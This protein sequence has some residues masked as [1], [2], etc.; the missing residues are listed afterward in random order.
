MAGKRYGKEEYRH[1]NLVGWGLNTGPEILLAMP[2]TDFTCMFTW[3]GWQGAGW[4]RFWVFPLPL[5]SIPFP[6]KSLGWRKEFNSSHLILLISQEDRG[7]IPGF[8]ELPS[9]LCFWQLMPEMHINEEKVLV[10]IIKYE[11]FKIQM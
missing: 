5:R 7:D 11:R 3:G 9:F 10:P 1:G 8:S 2:H 6:S 4:Q